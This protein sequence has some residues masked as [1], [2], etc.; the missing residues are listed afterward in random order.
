MKFL[1]VHFYQY[2]EGFQS[3]DKNEL[4]E[5]S[6]FKRYSGGDNIIENGSL[7]LS[8]FFIIQDHVEIIIDEK[9]V[10]KFKGGGQTF[11]EMSFVN[12]SLASAT[13][14]AHNEVTMMM[15]DIDKINELNDPIHYRMRMDIYRSCAEILAKK[16]KS[17]NDLAK[18]YISEP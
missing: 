1:K 8:L 18:F 2:F 16:L 11:G 3:I 9:I 6:Y 10:A 14:R 15:I 4:S 7:V 13:V 17:T 5:I 12:H